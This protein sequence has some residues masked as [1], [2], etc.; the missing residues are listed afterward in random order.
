MAIFKK[1]EKTEEEI[2]KAQER[3]QKVKNIVFN[4]LKVVGGI[5][6]FVAGA[7]LTLAAIGMSADSSTSTSSTSSSDDLT[8]T[9][10]TF[11]DHEES[12]ETVTEET[13]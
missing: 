2:K 4:G 13:I 1:K 8:E 5:V 12:T 9:D 10:V 3:G 7:A 11:I 6:V